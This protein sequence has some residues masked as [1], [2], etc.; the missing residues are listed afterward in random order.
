MSTQAV[1]AGCQE[2]GGTVYVLPSSITV[3]PLPNEQGTYSFPCPDCGQVSTNRLIRAAEE[4]FKLAVGIMWEFPPAE[5]TGEIHLGPPLTNDDLLMFAVALW[6][7]S[8]AEI[9]ARAVL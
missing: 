3:R 7:S 6:G 2:C 8:D 5:V 9:L 1:R 4:L